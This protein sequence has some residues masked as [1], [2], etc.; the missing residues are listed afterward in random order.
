MKRAILTV[1]FLFFAV[2]S[3]AQDELSKEHKEIIADFVSYFK[4]NDRKK[5]AT[6]VVYPLKREYPISSIKNKEEF[7]KRFDEVFDSKLIAMIVNSDMSKDWNAVGWRGIMLGN[8]SVWIDY[9]GTLLAVNYQSDA[10]VKKK[11]RLIELEKTNLHSSVKKF[12]NPV[13]IL[14]TK[15]YRIRIDEMPNGKYR[16]ASWKITTQM[17]DKP[18][19]IIENGAFFSLGSGGNHYYKF[20]NGKYIYECGIVLIGEDGSAPAYLAVSKDGNEILNEPAD[21]VA[22]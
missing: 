7:L 18:D 21:L 9:D 2:N 22:P 1:L 12:N 5:L 13:C 19:L 14:L 10:E 17:N 4:N 11:T 16:Y 6:L 3:N 20:K 8:G 15:K